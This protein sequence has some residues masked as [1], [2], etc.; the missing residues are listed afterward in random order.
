MRLLVRPAERSAAGKDEEAM[1]KQTPAKFTPEQYVARF[2]AEK[3][4]LQRH[5]CNAFKFWRTCPF[6][7]CRK[8]RTCGG[9]A[10]VCLKRREKEI[11]RH[12]QWQA[13]QQILESTP[14]SAGPAERMAR[15]FLP[16]TLV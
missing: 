16:G 4:R 13:R 10:D 7:R 15:E 9:D 2:N 11:P 8:A 1:S 12:I 6:K 5:Y 3:A 14:A